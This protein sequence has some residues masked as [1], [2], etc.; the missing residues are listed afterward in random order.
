[1]IMYAISR[2][3]ISAELRKLVGNGGKNH[4]HKCKTIHIIRVASFIR[5]SL[6]KRAI[7]DLMMEKI[8]NRAIQ[9]DV[10]ALY[11]ENFI[12][13]ESGSLRYLGLWLH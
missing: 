4:L 7:N 1:M 13:Q 3:I 8:V 10:P 5:S 2:G 9:K 12:N 6:T 11:I